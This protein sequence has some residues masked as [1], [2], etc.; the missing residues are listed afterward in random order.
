MDMVGIDAVAVNGNAKTAGQFG[1][2]LS[3]EGSMPGVK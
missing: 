3:Y 1:D 2:E